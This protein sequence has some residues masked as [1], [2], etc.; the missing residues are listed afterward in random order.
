MLCN[1]QLSVVDDDKWL[2]ALSCCGFH[3]KFGLA[4]TVAMLDVE[5]GGYFNY[6]HKIGLTS[7]IR[8]ALALELTNFRCV[9]SVFGFNNRINVQCTI[10]LMAKLFRR[11][12]FVEFC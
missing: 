6:F 4:K 10:R 7:S 2:S 1:F 9:E 11:L 12:H 5:D 8:L 3:F